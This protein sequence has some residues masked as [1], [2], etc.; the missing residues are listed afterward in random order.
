MRTDDHEHLLILSLDREPVLDGSSLCSG[1]VYTSSR[2]FFL[3]YQRLPDLK[4][5]HG[6]R[7]SP[8]RE[9]F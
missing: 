3:L 9:R 8:C 5:E 6:S 2:A 4:F 1:L 7:V